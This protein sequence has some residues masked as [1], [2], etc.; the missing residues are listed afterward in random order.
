MLRT[1]HGYSQEVLADKA[2]IHVTY[3]SG[4]ERGRR[5][6]T[7]SVLAT[8]ADALGVSLAT[9]FSTDDC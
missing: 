5:N 9:L 1:K 7:V 3:L 6:P 8:V 4:L 2:G